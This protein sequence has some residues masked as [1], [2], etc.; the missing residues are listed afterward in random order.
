LGIRAV[1]LSGLD[2]HFC[3]PAPVAASKGGEL[4]ATVF[5]FCFACGLTQGDLRTA[6]RATPWTSRRLLTS[7]PPATARPRLLASF[8]LRRRSEPHC[9]RSTGAPEGCHSS[10]DGAQP[11]PP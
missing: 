7:S 11:E 3:S 4:Q 9:L 2:L 1:R 8:R 10:P 5:L 6:S